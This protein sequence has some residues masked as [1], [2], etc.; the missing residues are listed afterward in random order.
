MSRPTW[1]I[2][3]NVLIS[4]ALTAGGTCHRVLNAAVE[5]RVQ[6]AWSAGILAEYR[7]V[8][9]RPK[10]GFPESIVASLLAAFSPEGQ[11]TP[12]DAPQLSDRDDEVFLATAL[13]TPDQVLVTGNAAHFP[14]NIC[15]PV[16][17]LTPAMALKSIA[18]SGG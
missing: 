15:H 3:T 11:V 10:F 17:I 2:D 8:L 13:A 14:K 16:K 7:A 1:V 4:A 6:L 12:A 5:G 9:V 18:Q